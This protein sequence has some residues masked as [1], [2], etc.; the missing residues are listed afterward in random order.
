MDSKT[1]AKINNSATKFVTAMNA[2][3]R[4]VASGASAK[5]IKKAERVAQ[6]EAA[7]ATKGLGS[8]NTQALTNSV[9]Q[10]TQEQKRLNASAKADAKQKSLEN[11][12]NR[13]QAKGGSLGRLQSGF[14]GGRQG[15]VA[16]SG[17]LGRLGNLAG[18]FGTGAA[19]SVKNFASSMKG[20]G[21]MTGMAASFALPML[22]GMIAPTK[23][24]PDRASFDE[25]TG[26]YRI[27][28]GAAR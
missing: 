9:S 6:K 20:F 25:G 27:T 10:L 23:S 18:R 14:Y 15:N 16:G 19:G 11:K 3:E 21:G 1:G 22:G 8:T 26:S 13:A 17:R 28:E 12:Q 24:R 4:R 2:L 5:D 7:N